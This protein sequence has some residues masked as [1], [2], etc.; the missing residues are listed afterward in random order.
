MISLIQHFEVDFLW[1]VSLIILKPF[2]HV[3]EQAGLNLTYLAMRPHFISDY[4]HN[5]LIWDTYCH[6]GYH[7]LNA[8]ASFE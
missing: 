4:T 8:E 6:Y 2:T 7:F 5:K 3:E 1:K